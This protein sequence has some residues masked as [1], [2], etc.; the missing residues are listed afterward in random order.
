M[1]SDLVGC[2]ALDAAVDVASLLA[3]MNSL[4]LK[5]SGVSS[6]FAYDE[7]FLGEEACQTTS[8]E[9]F[10]A[11]LNGGSASLNGT[12]SG[13]EYRF[14][15]GF[16][17]A[18]DGRS[19][20]FF[21]VSGRQIEKMAEALDKRASCYLGFFVGL[22]TALNANA[23]AFGMDVDYPS[24]IAFLRGELPLAEVGEFI[25]TA[26]GISPACERMLRSNPSVRE[27]AIGSAT[28]L[29]RWLPGLDQHFKTASPSQAR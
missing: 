4:E 18:R 13:A 26:A 6:R 28:V 15:L 17:A 16:F 23:M 24:L 20:S 27:I 3:F 8:W 5:F 22:R 11:D 29:S 9:E 25:V 7:D 2:L 12:F 14:S 10:R 19:Y 1:S 21:C